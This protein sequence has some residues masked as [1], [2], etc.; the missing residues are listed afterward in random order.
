MD[1]KKSRLQKIFVCASLLSLTACSSIT[2]DSSSTNEVDEMGD[3]SQ[4]NSATYLCNASPL[5]VFFHAED[6]QLTWNDKEYMLT[7]AVSASGSFYLGEGLSFWIHG[8][9]A[10]LEVG[11]MATKCR[12]VKV[13]S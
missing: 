11:T 4:T 7:Q 2:K 5:H 12:L 3:I 13:E 9:T 8:E 10:E 1:I 6:A